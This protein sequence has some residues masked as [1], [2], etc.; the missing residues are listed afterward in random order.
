MSPDPSGLTVSAGEKEVTVTSAN[1]EEVCTVAAE[2]RAGAMGAG[3]GQFGG[4]GGLLG[5]VA[6]VDSGHNNTLAAGPAG[7]IYVGGEG[8][9][10]RFD[11]E[12][13]YQ[14]QISLPEPGSVGSVAVD[15]DPASPNF[16]DVYFDYVSNVAGP[17]IAQ[18]KAEQPNVFRLDPA[19]GEVLGTLEVGIPA[20]L[21][22]DAEGDVYVTEEAYFGEGGGD[23][24]HH[25]ARVFEFDSAGKQIAKLFEG[26]L[27]KGGAL[28]LAT[29]VVDEAGGADLYLSNAFASGGSLRAYGPPP[30]KW[31]RPVVPPS[32]DATYATSV[33]TESA[34]V[35]AQVNPRFWED[36]RFYVQYG[37]GKCSE[38]GCTQTQPPLPGSLLTSEIADRDFT[39]SAV[40]LGGLAHDLPLPLPRQGRRRG[41]DRRRT[42]L[43]HLRIHRTER[44]MPQPGPAHGRLCQ[45]PRLPR[46]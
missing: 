43:A 12:G 15:D 9:I 2:C 11:A 40:I 32:I 41:N 44:Q 21:F 42:L 18:G 1:P 46:L 14:G 37:T 22:L 4:E 7:Q 27:K 30:L 5:G 8:R 38:G 36:T 45:P 3:N 25:Q 24:H 39:T 23:P 19:T 13:H 31:P 33:A 6:H 17:K 28:G 34:A 26:E 35:K 20:D 29:D 16:G 10:Q